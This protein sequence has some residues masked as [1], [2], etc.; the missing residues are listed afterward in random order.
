MQI[1]SASAE[2]QAAKADLGMMMLH[3]AVQAADREEGRV[4]KN[5][6]QAEYPPPIS[7]VPK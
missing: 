1:S 7:R 5:K 2:R 4:R 3:W 6:D